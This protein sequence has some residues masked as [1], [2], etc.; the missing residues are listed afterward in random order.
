M[1]F[2]S[3]RVFWEGF[4]SAFLIAIST[5]L[6]GL[7][8][9][10]KR[11][12][13]LGAGLS[14]AAFGGIA[15]ALVFEIDPMVFTLVYTV[16]LGLFIQFLVDRKS[17]PADTLVALFFSLGVALAIIILGI[18]DHLG[19]NVFSYLFGSILTASETDLLLSFL[20]FVTTLFFV[21]ANYRSLMLLSFNEEIGKLRGVR[22]G[23]LNY[24]LI[25]IASAN[26]VLSIKAVGLVLS[27]SFMSIPAMTSLLISSSFMQSLVFSV[28][29]SFLSLFSGLG[30]SLFL[31]LPPSGAVVTCM[32]F[33]FVLASFGRFIGRRFL[34]TS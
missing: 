30:L 12:A 5:S 15:L 3:Y 22:V 13:M 14:H 32:V 10:I 18:T 20:V 34:K 24:L 7:F 21:V 31:D 27:A 4:V 9:L 16:L 19:V 25:A 11:L 17:L 29:F 26:V 23:L 2:F 28:A 6:I 8:L 1:D 33:F